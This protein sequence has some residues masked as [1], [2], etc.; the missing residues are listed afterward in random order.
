MERR[1]AAILFTDV[2]GYSTLMGRDEAAARRVRT[3]HESLVREQITRYDGQW[4]EEKG[5]ESL[6][7][8][9]SAVQAVGCALAIQTELARDAGFQVRI[10]IHLGDVTLEDGRVYGD[11]VNVAARIYPLAE[12][13]EIA[14]SG[15]VHDSIKNQPGVEVV[16][17]GE[18]T[19]KNVAAPVVVWSVTGALGPPEASARV[20]AAASRPG[21]RTAT[22]LAVA[23]V[24]IGLL[25]LWNSRPQVE[26]TPIRSV[27]V[28]PLHDSSSDEVGGYLSF[29]MTE[30]LITELA[31]LGDLSV[32]SRTSVTPYE[33]TDLSIRQIAAELGVDGIIEGSVLRSG[34]RVRVTAQLIDARSDTH[35]WAESYDR[36]VGDVLALHAELAR[37]IAREVQV[38]VSPAPPV[39]TGSTRPISPAAYEAYLKGYY[40]Q[41][42]R[43]REDTNRAV[44]YFTK[45]IE[46]EPDHP[47][48][49]SGLADEYSCAPTHSWSIVGSELWPSVPREMIARARSNAQRAL[50]LDPASGPAHNS[51]ALVL[52]VWQL[53]LVGGGGRIPRGNRAEPGSRVGALHLR[54]LTG[55]PA[56]LR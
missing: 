24:L 55:L 26:S 54:V 15:S 25:V 16:C 48:G 10:G 17:K 34:E 56:P 9:P 23:V 50:E 39:G 44:R 53:G 28:L 45:V 29:G 20:P 36:D 18:Q 12:P 2:V 5:D 8:F 43:T 38:E 4:I 52:Y 31:K 51:I 49:Y 32:I 11:G 46:L 13:G 40:F 14:V 7:V 35:I 42:K 33:T 19:L 1:L 6:S 22:A 27:A 37:A 30:A 3:R 21:F 47:L 41:M